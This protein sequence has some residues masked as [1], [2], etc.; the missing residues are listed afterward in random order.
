VAYPSGTPA[1]TN[2][3]DALNR[4][5]YRLDGLSTTVYSYAMLG[6][7][8]HTVTENGPWAS[9]D[10]TVTNR[11][12]P[13]RGRSGCSRP[14]PVNAVVRQPYTVRRQAVP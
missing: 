6:N 3:F 9:D 2:W 10:V 4:L 12:G 11:H 1:I 13:A 5:T 14:R 8:Q 7:G